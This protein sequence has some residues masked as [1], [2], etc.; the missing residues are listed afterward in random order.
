MHTLDHL[1]TEPELEAQVEPAAA[2][3]LTNLELIP[4]KPSALQPM[5]LVFLFESLHYV[6]V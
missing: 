6:L 2:E 5:I 3:E 4:G 1:H